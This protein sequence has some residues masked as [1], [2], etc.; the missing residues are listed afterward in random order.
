MIDFFK[1]FFSYKSTN[2]PPEV[3]KD[4]LPDPNL[5]RSLSDHVRA[6]RRTLV[7]V[8]SICIAWSSAQFTILEPKINIVGIT[9]DFKNASIPIVLAVILSYVTIRW[10]IEFAMM[11]RHTRR[12][13]LAQLDFKL[14]IT[15]VRF[16]FL[17]IAAGALDRSLWVIVLISITILLLAIT[18]IMLSIFLMF[19]T[20]PIRMRARSRAKKISAAN[21]SFEALNW[22]IFFAICIIVISMIGLGIASY[23]YLPLRE[24][25]WSEPPNPIALSTFV[26]TLIGVFL[27]HWLLRPMINL[28]FAERPNY[29]TEYDSDGALI[30]H[31]INTE[32]EP[33]I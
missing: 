15:L 7:I 4:E 5:N 12:W 32:K 13:P 9:F 18:T 10:G 14:L 25:L 6:S 8:C 31:Y 3:P 28:I 26:I 23:N 33:L 29:Y 20:M 17:A 16:S 21:A 27:S 22:A 19:I 1:H 11:P 24:F 30:I 2:L